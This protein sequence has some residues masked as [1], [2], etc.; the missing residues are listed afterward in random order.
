MRP[1]SVLDSESRQKFLEYN[2][3]RN[4]D[5]RR[6]KN[7]QNEF[8]YVSRLKALSPGLKLLDIGCGPGL[9][10]AFWVER[11]VEGAGID[12]RAHFTNL[13]GIRREE[14]RGRPADGTVPLGDVGIGIHIDFY[15]D[16][17]LVYKG[18]DCGILVGG[19]YR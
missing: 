10:T 1:G 13:L 17:V 2:A 16:K 8:K 18:D 7:F 11:G 3:A 19:F 12:I 5:E 15:G 6:S 4:V 9:F 14:G